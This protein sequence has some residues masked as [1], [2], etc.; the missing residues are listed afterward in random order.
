LALGIR[1]VACALLI[2]VDRGMS[3][4]VGVEL[5]SASSMTYP[6]AAVGI[7]MDSET[8]SVEH[9]KRVGAMQQAA[10]TAAAHA[11]ENADTINYVHY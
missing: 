2:T 11:E 4:G 9:G 7:G 5:G 1:E 3:V 6:G 10:C 8:R